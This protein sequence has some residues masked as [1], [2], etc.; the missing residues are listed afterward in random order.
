VFR[1]HAGHDVLVDVDPER[2]RAIV[3][4]IRG[5]PNRGLRDFSSTRA[6]MS[7]SSGRFG[8]G[9]FRRRVDENGRRYLRRTKA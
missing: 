2:V 5:Q 6:L 4:S 3:R 9:F 1:Q 8:P 7:A